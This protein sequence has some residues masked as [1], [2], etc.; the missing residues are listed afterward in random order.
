MNKSVIK[1]LIFIFI[2]TSVFINIYA[3]KTDTLFHTNGNILTGEVKKFSKGLLYFKM[4]GM[5]TLKVENEEIKS[6]IS[7]KFLRILTKN[8]KVYYGDIDSSSNWGELKVGLLDERDLII[9]NDITEIYPINNTFWLRLNGRVD[10]GIDYSKANNMLRINGSGQINYQRERWGWKYKYNNIETWQ[11]IDTLDQ[12][13]KSDYELSSEYFFNPIYR[14]TGTIGRNSNTELGLK[15]RWFAALSV[16][17]YI[18][19]T[20]RVSLDYILGLS[21]NIERNTDITDYNTNFEV[22]MGA[23][24]GI[25]KYKSPDISVN[26]FTQVIPNIKT[27]GRWRFDSGFDAKVE[28]FTDFY[29]IG[30]LYYQYDSMPINETSQTNDYNFTMGFGYSFN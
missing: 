14:I 24:L 13:T 21:A 6:L 28:V 26:L 30:K 4:D 17:K 27:R 3:Q 7:N 18:I 11:F 9:V 8:N 2:N 1:L 22:V 15:A 25:F 20:N 5:G 12:T 19:Q 10:F 29:I 16:K 23:D